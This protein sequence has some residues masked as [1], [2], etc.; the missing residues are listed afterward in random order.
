MKN[1]LNMKKST[2]QLQGMPKELMGN[3]PIIFTIKDLL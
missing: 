3:F 1:N 2:Q